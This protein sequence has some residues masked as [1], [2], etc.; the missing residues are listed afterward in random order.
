MSITNVS[1]GVCLCLAAISAFGDATTTGTQYILEF[2][3]T[4]TVGARFQGYVADANSQT[5]AFDATGPTG[6]SQMVFKPDGS[7]SYIL[8]SGGIQSVDPAF[9]PNSFRSING[10]TGIGTCE[11]VAN[12]VWNP[13]DTKPPC[14]MAISPDGK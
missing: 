1:L 10:I 4:N 2:P 13:A 9:G 5:P 3:Q 12:Q 7:K 14:T 6:V 11:S 8:G